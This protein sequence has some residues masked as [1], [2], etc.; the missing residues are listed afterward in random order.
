MT[1]T[2]FL[3]SH[4]VHGWRRKYNSQV[5]ILNWNFFKALTPLGLILR[6]LRKYG[7]SHRYLSEDKGWLPETHPLT[8]HPWQTC[9]ESALNMHFSIAAPWSFHS[10]TFKLAFLKE[11]HLPL[12]YSRSLGV[13]N[14]GVLS[15]SRERTWYQDRLHV[16]TSSATCCWLCELRQTT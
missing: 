11:P 13:W 3:A 5:F 4:K 12:N 2:L 8:L 10:T 9:G 15:S 6:E 14:A 1:L 7:S 16:N